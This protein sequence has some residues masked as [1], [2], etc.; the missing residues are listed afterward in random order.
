M[1]L[2]DL[3]S[4]SGSRSSQ[5]QRMDDDQLSSDALGALNY[6]WRKAHL[7]DDWSKGGEISSAWDRW[8]VYPLFATP[9]Y[10]VSWG[11]RAAAKI[12][13][14]LPAWREGIA[15]IIDLH[16][17]RMISFASWHDWVDQP[18]L[19]PNRASYPYWYY[20]KYIP[21]GM[22]GVYN[23]PGYCG[24]GLSTMQDGFF[25]AWVLA[26]AEPRSSY[27]YT[28]DHSPGI[29]REFDPDP[30]YGNGCAFL[31]FKGYL[32]EQLGHYFAVSGDDKYREP[33]DV[34]YDDNTRFSYS[35]EEIAEV[36]SD[37]HSQ[38]MDSQYSSMAPGI[39]C[40]VGKAF[41]L[42]IGTGGLGL[43]LHD[44]L[45]G[46]DYIPP[47][48]EWMEWAKVNAAMS[49]RDDG[50][51]DRVTLYYD[52]DL[53]YNHNPGGFQAAFLHAVTALQC[54][55]FAPEWSRQLYESSLE[56]F[57]RRQDDGG[58]GIFMPTE[59]T[60]SQFEQPD[61]TGGPPMLALAHEFGDTETETALRIYAEAEWGPSRTNHEFWYEFGI[62]EEFPRGI[63]NDFAW[64]AEAGGPGSFVD[65][66][67]SS[68]MSKL[69]LPSVVDIDY[70]TVGV[71]RARS[72]PDGVLHLGI[73]CQSDARRGDR[74]TFR[75]TQ[76]LPHRERS[77]LQDG[78]PH[79]AWQLL[80]NGDMVVTTTIDAHDFVIS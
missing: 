54:L 72:T 64:I 4:N 14:Q 58:L 6:L 20:D 27:P 19:D 35:H 57:G 67:K 38:P 80:D 24:N 73:V 13:H 39:D 36:L 48:E 41:P 23:A 32:L 44:N 43:R 70:P 3:P 17:Q 63:P 12:G 76:L 10:D 9:R 40:E 15:E 5:P 49:T 55:P 33:F 8:S 46:T 47:F 77:V 56:L 29:G 37:Q 53:S 2:T 34:V 22:A 68:D 28:A 21:P 65:M 50:I 18:G 52:R 1:S 59:L 71:R 42:C 60:H 78:R 66:Y 62:P 11:V 74:T 69:D 51:L 16:I 26:P 45:F 25:Q 61:R 79:D 31:M 30:I 75:V 7:V